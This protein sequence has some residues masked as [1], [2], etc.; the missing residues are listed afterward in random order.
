[1]PNE[2]G[3]YIESK[4][5]RDLITHVKDRADQLATEGVDHA[6]LM[7]RLTALEKALDE[8]AHDSVVG[9]KLTE[10][11][12]EFEDVATSSTVRGI[13]VLLNEIL[14]TGVPPPR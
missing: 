13:V 12:G 3:P 11:K 4:K 1:M 5:T 10:L 8:K 14:G 9:Q 6:T 2:L 7:Q